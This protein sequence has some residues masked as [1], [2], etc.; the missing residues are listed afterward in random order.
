[1]GEIEYQTR[2]ADPEHESLLAQLQELEEIN[3]VLEVRLGVYEKLLTERETQIRQRQAAVPDAVRELIIAVK[4]I[5]LSSHHRVSVEGAE[6]PGYW[7]RGD[8]A[9]RVLQLAEEAEADLY[10]SSDPEPS[11]RSWRVGQ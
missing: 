4:T 9:R 1:M 3:K 2:C 10:R 5:N 8:W 11:G 6:E 7:Q